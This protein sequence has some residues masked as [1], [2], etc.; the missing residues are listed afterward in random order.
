MTP[1]NPLAKAELRA[2]QD[3]TLQSQRMTAG[4]LARTLFIIMDVVYGR[5]GSL[6]K[7]RVLEV[8]ARVP[9]MAWEHVG[10]VAITHTHSTPH[11]AR[12]IHTEVQGHRA[13][14]DNELFHLLILEELLQHRG[15]RQGL[16][17]FRIIPQILATTYY[18]VSWLLFVI[19]PRLSY[20]LN[21]EFEDHAEHEYMEFVRDNPE[22]ESE[23]WVSDFVDDYGS[24]ETIADL[25]RQI[26]VDERHHKLES[27]ESIKQARFGAGRA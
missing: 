27:L 21:A 19:R 5:S 24:F 6:A 26:A 22:F 12:D 16:I 15:E 8:I 9:Y 20:Q 10:Y 23:A 3:I 2:E 18:Y 14:Q 17:R 4:F 13:Q 11:F 1:V 25:L 7:F